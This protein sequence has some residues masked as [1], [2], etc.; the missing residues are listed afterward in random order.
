MNK[1]LKWG[2]IGVGGFVLLLIIIGAIAS[3][4]DTS[5]TTEITNSQPTPSGSDKNNQPVEA[6]TPDVEP[7]VVDTKQFITDF[8][9]NQ[10]AAEEKYK[11]QTVKLTAYIKNISEDI[12]GNPFL[13]LQPTSD[14]YYFGTS[15]QCIFKNKSELI[16][17]ENGQQVT[18]VGK[19]DSQDI[20][21]IGIDDCSIQK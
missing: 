12:L 6:T 14:E 13:S 16:S 2:C 11:G 7:L 19:V 20:G 1:F 18:I 3:S 17:V 9:K 8:D 10:L 21:I 15:I 4:N 5:N